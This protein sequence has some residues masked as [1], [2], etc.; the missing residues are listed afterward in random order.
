V[1]YFRFLYFV[2]IQELGLLYCIIKYQMSSFIGKW[3]E[4]VEIRDR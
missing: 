4:K 3:M 1:I 2:F